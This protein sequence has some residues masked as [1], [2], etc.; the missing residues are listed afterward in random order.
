[1]DIPQLQAF[2]AVAQ[3]GS[4]SAAA[5]ALDLTQPAI[6][7]RVASLEAQ[8][9]VRLFDRIARQIQL[10]E[11]GTRLQGEAQDILQRLQQ[12]PGLVKGRADQVEGQ[13]R[14]A[15]SHHICLLYTS[16]SPRDRG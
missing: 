9:R 2:I 12:L 3:Q 5:E 10:T 14:I 8:L 13:L 16:P 7:K 15:T 11:A 6:S 4:F 1:M